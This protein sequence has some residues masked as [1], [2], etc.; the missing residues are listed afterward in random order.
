M[1]QTYAMID[2]GGHLTFP[3]IW[4]TAR[5]DPLQQLYA[6]IGC[7]TV[8]V[9]QLPDGTDLWVDD[10]GMINGQVPNAALT[11]Y[12]GTF[13]RPML[14]VLYGAGILTGRDDD[15]NVVPITE[16]HGQT[17]DYHWYLARKQLADK[18]WRARAVTHRIDGVDV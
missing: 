17:I 10:N 9:I 18:A 15:G 7:T 2:T 16:M 1:I 14:Q 8:D 4:D 5:G 3:E 6:L 12:V 13:G 11:A